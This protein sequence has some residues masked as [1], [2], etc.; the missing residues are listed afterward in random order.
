MNNTRMACGECQHAMRAAGTLRCVRNAPR[1]I[2]GSVSR[3]SV[4]GSP[5]CELERRAGWGAAR[6]FG[7]CGAEGRFWSPT[8]DRVPRVGPRIVWGALMDDGEVSGYVHED[9]TA[10]EQWAAANI[11][12][13]I[14]AVTQLQIME[15]VP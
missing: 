4:I 2:G 7:T 8:T 13:G 11:V 12:D 14:Y 6:Y 3:A 10:V 15:R 1:D 9:R 5:Y